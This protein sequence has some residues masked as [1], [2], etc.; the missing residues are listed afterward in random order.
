MRLPILSIILFFSLQVAVCQN[1]AQAEVEKAVETLKLAMVDPNQ[2]VLETIVADKLSY[3]HSSGKVETKAQFIESL[4]SGQSDFVN[5]ELSNQA[6]SILQK[7]ALVRHRL[8]ANTNNAGIPGTVKLDILLVFQKQGK[9]WVLIARQA[10]K[11][12]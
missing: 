1:K 5:I 11:V 9:N 2:K 6:V 10:V 3:G 7:T 12:A 4:L 8:S